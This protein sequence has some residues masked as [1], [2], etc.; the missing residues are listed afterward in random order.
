MSGS[1]SYRLAVDLGTT[2]TAAA[3]DE[4]GSVSMVGLGNRALQ[5][6]SVL[7]LNDD[8]T[9]LV[10]EAAERR[11][12]AEPERLAREFK[13][14][15]G[16]QVPILVGGMSQSPQSLTARLLQWVLETSAER[17][18]GQPRSVVLTHP[19]GWGPFKIDVL[20]QA[21]RLADLDRVELCPEPFAAAARYA[22]RSRVQPGQRVAV[23]DLGGGTFD[24][25]VLEKTADG[26]RLLGT[27]EGVEQL[28]GVDFDKALLGQVSS[29][30]DQQFS[31][32]D[33]E[34]LAV[35]AGLSRLQRD[36][37]EAKEGL[38][39]DVEAVIPV[40]LPGLA[41]SIRVTRSE[42]ER[43]IRPALLDT[44]AATNRALRSAGLGPKDLTAIL[45]AGG[46]SRIP[47]VGELL[48]REFGVPT[49]LD[50]HP[51][52]D[53]AAGALLA[54]RDIPA[55]APKVE[56]GRPQPAPQPH[57]APTGPAPTRPAPTRPAPTLPAAARPVPP[58]PTP[59]RP[60][61]PRP[62]PPRPMPQGTVPPGPG[63]QWLI[64]GSPRQAGT[65]AR[66]PAATRQPRRSLK[67]V[68]FAS[69]AVVGV[70]V[71]ALVV[72]LV[73]Y[74][75]D[76]RAG[77][78]DPSPSTAG[79]PSP[80]PSSSAA[81]TP[82]GP[83]VS[84]DPTTRAY[85]LDGLQ[86]TMPGA[87]YVISRP[88][89]T[90]LGTSGV[91]IR[92]YAVVHPD[93]DGDGD[94]WA[95]AVV[96][97][98]VGP[99][100]TGSSL[101]QT[102]DKIFAQWGKVGFAGGVTNIEDEKKTTVTDDLPRPTRVITADVYYTVSGIISQYDVVSLMVTQGQSGQYVALISSWPNDSD[103]QIKSALQSSI[104]TVGLV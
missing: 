13:R 25:C 8:G 45:L 83:A 53:V 84:Y 47:L 60:T 26:F 5:I 46:S 99:E 1:V 3:V 70:A 76:R 80:G 59:P 20:R 75:P 102:A 61:P 92:A 2:F 40:S 91:G 101:D 93:Y 71:V 30:L 27:P 28:G 29:S 64:A 14:R 10:G 89:S 74:P 52:H 68:W 58:R 62:T 24:A 55:A 85:A 78:P 96:V 17:M 38:S 31:D 82:T 97:D 86:I 94:D 32:P 87:P 90:V 9:F 72:A 23:Y 19:A 48:Q 49:A 11:G 42:F 41:T 22:A 65:A 50:T 56:Q 63:D 79:S 36:C 95:A 35:V 4:S 98:V 44:I 51:K 16:D 103:D 21:G 69:A 33:P 43:L 66:R 37:V 12:L 81:G 100:L 104:N 34:D 39:A 67:A 15:V 77:P 57:P 7:F 54:V 73:S 18:G 6:P 88:T